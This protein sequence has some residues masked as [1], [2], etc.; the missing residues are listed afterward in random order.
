VLVGIGFW[1]RLQIAETPAFRRV[2][3]EGQTAA[4]PVVEAVRN[5]RSNIVFGIGAKIAESG[6]F[7]IYAVF[8]ITYCVSKLSM[9]RQTI[10]HGVL[11]GAVLEC[12]TLPIFGTLTDRVGRRT[13]YLGGMIFQAALAYPFFMMLNSGSSIL[14][15]IA[16]SL[17]LAIGHG[18]VYG[19][20]GVFFSELFPA[21]VRYSGLSLV[22]QIGPILGGGLSPL[23][24]TS[25]LTG[26][27]SVNAV[28]LYMA[29]AALLS[30]CCA[31][32]LR[33]ASNID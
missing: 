9:P 31:L 32:G 2:Q 17:G 12:I 20:Q 33:S 10:L 22:Q 23:I 16:I 6:L 4:I 26:F 27:G 19:A 8:A 15:Y 14:I 13:V 1:I 18:S 29:G 25:L 11:I 21:R 24:A 30:A 28:A 7:N 5:H 3:A